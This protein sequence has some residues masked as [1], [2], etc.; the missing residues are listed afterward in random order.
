MLV[1]HHVGSQTEPLHS[2]CGGCGPGVLE[3]EQF[4]GCET[5]MEVSVWVLAPQILEMLH[6]RFH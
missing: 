4:L 1:A 3:Y 6:V 2:W 5:H